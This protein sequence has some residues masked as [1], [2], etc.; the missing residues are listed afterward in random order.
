MSPR[1]K[2]QWNCYDWETRSL[3]RHGQRCGWCTRTERFDSCGAAQI[4]AVDSSVTYCFQTAS[5]AFLQ[6]ASTAIASE[7]EA[8]LSEAVEGCFHYCNQKVA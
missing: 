2:V 3:T 5:S 7:E 1:S 6:S 8:D 4:Q